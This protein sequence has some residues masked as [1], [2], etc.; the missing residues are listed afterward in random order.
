MEECIRRFPKYY[1]AY[2]YRGKLYLKLK[3]YKKALVDFEK[4]N[5]L[6][7]VKQMG[8]IGKGDCL[9]LMERYK[10]AKAAYSQAHTKKNEVSL[11]LRQAICSM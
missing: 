11:L 3:Q 1:E 2:I 6:E 9:R 10:E 7:P 5:M 8:L 4:A